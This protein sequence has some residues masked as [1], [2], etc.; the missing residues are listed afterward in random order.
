M[1]GLS[2]GITA[3]AARPG[4]VNDLGRRITRARPGDTVYAFMPTVGNPPTAVPHIVWTLGDT[5]HLGASFTL[6]INLE[7][8]LSWSGTDSMGNPVQS[9]GSVEV[10]TVDVMVFP[11]PPEEEEEEPDPIPVDPDPVNDVLPRLT[12]SMQVGETL[13]VTPGVWT[14]V[15]QIRARLQRQ[16]EDSTTW[17]DAGAV[18]ATYLVTSEDAGFRLRVREVPDGSGAL[19]VMSVPTDVIAADQIETPVTPTTP[20]PTTTP[21]LPTGAAVFG[22]DTSVGTGGLAVDAPDGTYGEFAVTAGVARPAVSPLT[23]GTAQIGTQTVEVRRDGDRDITV[24]SEDEVIALAPHTLSTAATPDVTLRLR[25]GVSLASETT[26]LFGSGFPRPNPVELHGMVRLKFE[27]AGDGTRTGMTYWRGQGHRAAD[28]VDPKDAGI[29]IE[30][31]TFAPG[32]ATDDSTLIL[33]QNIQRTTFEVTDVRFRGFTPLETFGDYGARI[34]YVGLSGTFQV[35]EKIAASVWNTRGER[36]ILEVRDAGDGTGTLMVNDG[37]SNSQAANRA[38]DAEVGEVITGRVGGATAVV[39]R[40]AYDTLPATPSGIGVNGNPRPDHVIVR[41]C[42]F[43]D[44]ADVV[45]LKANAS[46]T[47][48]D[49]TIERYLK[50]AFT[51]SPNLDDDTD[52]TVS[53]QVTIRGNRVRH[54]ISLPTDLGNPHSD[55]LQIND[56]AR[57]R[58]WEPLVLEFNQFMDGQSRGAAQ[59]MFLQG[60]EAFGSTRICANILSGKGSVNTLVGMGDRSSIVHNNTVFRE[61]QADGTPYPGFNSPAAVDGRRR[62]LRLQHR[63]PGRLVRHPGDASR[64]RLCQAGRPDR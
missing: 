15:T 38:S 10:S 39:S 61:L 56:H 26:E 60:P 44:L 9:T 21:T 55:G 48:E 46:I 33:L 28:G 11:Q 1:I 23:V 22:A 41:N 18:G 5:T 50:D 40:A 17:S 19:S 52:N 8:T 43:A 12:G 29:A 64:Q 59:L 3:T 36:T 34:D 14:N 6:P 13:V 31:C 24:A 57:A 35:G 7:G 53:P 42:D 37:T 30:G 16:A 2:L 62:P 47:L 49:N 32:N 58:L 27:I 63:H 51:V 25:P 4:I 45:T 54:P 20:E